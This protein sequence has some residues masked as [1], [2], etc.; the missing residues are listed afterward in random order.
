[1]REAVLYD[2]HGTLVDVTS[3]HGYL[4]QRKY[5]EFYLASLACPRIET[6]VLA[7]RQSHE[8]GYQNILFTGM[9]NEY[10]DGLLAWLGRHGV[11]IDLIDMRPTGD[12]RKDFIVKREMYLRTLD[13]GIRVVR[14]WDDN[15]V[16]LD[17]WEEQAIPVVRV[18]EWNG[19]LMKRRVDKAAPT[20]LG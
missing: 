18:P 7:A 5:E 13:Q 12:F 9:P 2:F 15:P 11:P 4:A 8:A 16:I 10:R 20:V 19:N 17:L 14:A 1:M 6:T 3:V